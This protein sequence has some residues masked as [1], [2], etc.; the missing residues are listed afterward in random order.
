MNLNN[1]PKNQPSICI[2]LVN[3]DINYAFIYNIFKNIN[4]GIISKI[5]ILERKSYKNEKYKRVFIHLKKWFNTPESCY[6]RERLINGLDVKIVYDYPWFWKISANKHLPIVPI[7]IENIS[8]KLINNE[9]NTVSN[10][11]SNNE[12]NDEIIE[13]TV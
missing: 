6:I 5:D 10:T 8:I 2:P 3:N 1:I 7:K 11:V 13:L 4:I 9:T 12:T